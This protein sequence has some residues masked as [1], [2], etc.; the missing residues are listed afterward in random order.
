MATPRPMPELLPVMSAILSLSFMSFTDAEAAEDP[1][2]QVVARDLAG[3]L[4]EVALCV[5]QLLRDQFPR[6]A[7]GEQPMRF[8]DVGAR[9]TQ[10]VEVTAA[11]RKCAI[12]RRM[13]TDAVL[14]MS[15]QTVESAACRRAQVDTRGRPLL[16][17]LRLAAAVDLVKDDRARDVS[18]ELREVSVDA[19]HRDGIGRIDDE[20][21]AIGSRHFTV[22]TPYPL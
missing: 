22:R 10:R 11:G 9:T 3:D 20:Q 5:V 1:P 16:H 17:S 2:E 4:T 14:E 6:V 15:P 19:G 18:R 12:G 21:H 7:F 13:E 8:L